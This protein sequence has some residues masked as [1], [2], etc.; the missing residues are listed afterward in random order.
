[1]IKD[2]ITGA[3]LEGEVTDAEA[4]LRDGLAEVKAEAKANG[5]PTWVLVVLAIAA[6]GGLILL[7]R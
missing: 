5:I 4:K 2:P 6:I 7:F 3:G 1:M